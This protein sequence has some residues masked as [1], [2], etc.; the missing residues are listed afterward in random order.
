M[1]KNSRFTWKDLSILILFHGN[2]QGNMMIKHRIFRHPGLASLNLHNF[3][4]RIF[5][6]CYDLS[7][8]WSFQLGEKAKGFEWWFDQQKM[9]VSGAQKLK[10][11]QQQWQQ[12]LGFSSEK[13][14]NLTTIDRKPW[15]S[16]PSNS[17]T[18]NSSSLTSPRWLRLGIRDASR[19]R[20]RSFHA[21][22]VH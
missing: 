2:F 12:R 9:A 17:E 21:P 22:L 11:K 5:R 19:W 18:E 1:P 7:A 6:T 3:G 13:R 20:W 14:Q 8:S 15:V 4:C 16:P 10:V